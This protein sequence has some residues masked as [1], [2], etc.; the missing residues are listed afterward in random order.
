MIDHKKTHRDNQIETLFG[1]NSKNYTHLIEIL[2]HNAI[3]G[4][5]AYNEAF[6]AWKSMFR[7]IYGKNLDKTL[8]LKHTYYFLI[9]KFLLRI[10]LNRIGF[11]SEF[12]LNIY[13]MDENQIFNWL[14]TSHKELLKQLDFP[15][16]FEF[17]EEDLFNQLYQEIIFPKTRHLMGEYYTGAILARKMTI[18]TY[19]FGKRVLDPS[20]GSGIFLV[21]ILKIILSSE[22]DYSECYKAIED[23]YGFDINPLAIF[24]CKI[25]FLLILSNHLKDENL[26]KIKLNLNCI[27]SLF[28][29]EKSIEKFKHSFDLVLG[30]PPWLT[31]KDLKNKQYQDKIRTLAADLEIKPPSQYTTHI[32][33]AAV[34][35]YSIPT[36]FLKINGKI[37]F[38]VTKSILNGDHCHKF[39]SFKIFKDLEIWDFPDHYFFNI[40]HI[41]LKATYI[42]NNEIKMSE[43]YPIPTKIFNDRVEM[44]NEVYYDSI[45]LNEDGAK[46]ILLLSE[47]KKLRKSRDS[48]YKKKFLQ[49]ATLVP[50]TLI[51]FEIEKKD[52]KYYTIVPD[53]DVVSRAKKNWKFPFPKTKIEKEFRY[54]TFLNTDLVPF[55]VKRFRN[56]FIPINR[57][58]FQFDLKLLEENPFSNEFYIEQDTI[59]KQ[60][61]KATS[62]INSLFE[63]LNYW[64]K[65]TKQSKNKT[66][67]V[68]YNA[69]GSTLKS[70]VIIN[71]KKKIIIGS[72]NYYFSTS[73]QYEAYYLSAILNSPVFSK[74]IKLIKSSRHIHKRPFSFPIPQYDD[75]NPTHRNLGT[76]AKKYH[77]VVRDLVLNN[78]KISPEK[79]RMFIHPKLVKLD[80]LVDQIVFN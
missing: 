79:V 54:L 67:I 62:S 51:F 63:N 25:N 42:G 69:S 60:H 53:S 14:D 61:K 46:V 5:S 1:L 28:P 76:K 77:T 8:Y 73:S 21:E 38:V 70:A 58:D 31:Y 19:K 50:R 2:A 29:D 44:Q 56:V 15:S 59:Y 34:F 48:S 74:N 26:L 35:F 13:F 37:F 75:D 20:C 57:D 78:P 24:T 17:K 45:E 10:K 27:D 6:H 30:N 3:E 49:G 39:R 47:I 16:Q 36:D 7:S 80:S 66:F 41:C 9:L 55:C 4:N 32:E 40:D 68:V 65:L 12:D 33:L 72:E 52:E 11:H 18:D 23:I 71:D 43:K 22:R 64:N